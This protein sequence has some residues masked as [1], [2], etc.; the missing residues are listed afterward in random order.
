MQPVNGFYGEYGGQF[1]PELLMPALDELEKAF[2]HFM[3]SPES[4][5]ELQNYLKNYVGR[6]TPIYYAKNISEKYGLHLY[7]KREDLL[8]TGAHKVNNTIGQAVLTKYM[9]KKRVIAE[10]GAGQ[11]GVATATA[12]ALFGFD[13]TIYM[14]RIDAE[15]QLPNVKKMKLL[16][17]KVK[18]V[19][20][21]QKTLKDAVSA[22]LKDWVANVTDTHYLI[23][24]VVGPHP[25]PEIVASFQSVIGKEAREYFDASDIKLDTVV[26]CVGG[27][28][29]A[30]GIFQGF[31]DDNKVSLVGVEAGGRSLDPGENSATIS[32]GTKGIFQGSLTYLLQNKAY[33]VEDVHSVSAGLDYPGTGPHHAYLHDKGLVTYGHVFDN[34][35]LKAF[36]ELTRLEGIIP[37]LESS[38]ALAYVLE[39]A[40]SYQG[41][42]VLVNL[43]GRGDKDM[44]IVNKINLEEL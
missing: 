43:S 30:I 10:T 7:L 14:G 34:E 11:H 18:L 32:R 37:A 40:D 15:R 27:G 17:A 33:Q 24:S 28:S 35:A 44:E 39:N 1:A 42:H 26:A 8:H 3:N 16:G 4:I 22:S 41:K 13:C 23:G 5:G 38:H 2:R 20:D 9:K 6:P 36:R 21:G 12:A 25:F 19:E 31:L 29:N